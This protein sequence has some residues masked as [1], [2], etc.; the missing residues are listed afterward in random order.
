[1]ANV[2]QK[3][4][5]IK[6]KMDITIERFCYHPKG[7]LGVCTVAGETFYTIE[8][9]WLDNA[10]NVS[11]VPT[12]SYSMTWR[13]SPRFGWTWMLEDVPGRTYILI[14]AANYA[15]DVQGCI[16]LGTSLMGDRVAVSNS[17]KAV[18]AF[19]ELTQGGSC[20]IHI[21][22]VLHAALKNH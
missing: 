10:P 2:P 14:H 8:R 20:Q 7:T 18:A 11:C 19:D 17:R 13:E 16:G 22:D 4:R 21:S 9:P 15:S 3:T 5:L 6:S 12:G 1:V